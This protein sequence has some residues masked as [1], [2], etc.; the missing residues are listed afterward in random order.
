MMQLKRWMAV[1][2]VAML[3]SCGGG[4]G[5]SGSSV[6]PNPSGTAKAA[7]LTLVL[8]A[9]SVSNSGS[10]TVTA[11]VTAVDANRNTVAGI[12][13]TLS[14]NN[15]AT[16]LVS[17]TQTDDKGVVTGAVGIGG[18]KINRALVV[19][20]TSGTLTR[21]VVLQVVGAKL[22]ATLLPA[23]LAPSAAGKVQ[24][25]LL[26]I[27]SNPMVGVEIVVI[28]PSGQ[29][30]TAAT[31]SNG[32]YEFSYVAPAVAGAV[33]IRAAAGGVETIHSVIV[34]AGQGVIPVVVTPVQSASVSANP[35]VVSV[36]TNSTVNR[37]EIRAL[38]LAANNAPIKNIRVRLDLDGDPNFIGGSFT[39]GTSLLYS[40]AGGVAVGAYVPGTR[41]SPTDGVTVRACWDYADF[42]EGT[43]PNA[44]RTN[45]T[46]VAEPL[47]VSIGTNALI[48]FD[49]ANL[50]YIKKYVIQVVD[51]SGQAKQDVQVSP[52]LDLLRFR[53]GE[54]FISGD[55]WVK[56]HFDPPGSAI[57]VLGD[58]AICDNEDVNRN[59]V[60]EVFSNGVVED[61]NQSFNL[62][63][64]RPALEP[65]KA[66]V[67]WSYVGSSKTDATGIVIIQ[68]Q[69]PQNLGSWVDFNLTV[70]ASGVSGTEG[71]ANFDG[72]LPVPGPVLVDLK[73]DP[74]FIV[75]PYGV[76]TSP[77][78][79]VS[80]PGSSKQFLLCTNPN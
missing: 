32:D 55:R 58:A 56:F 29:Q 10:D 43:C 53:K 80:P 5:D 27:N 51:S 20:A 12:P 25:R 70:S 4:G 77:V 57:T 71:R 63:N 1:L 79:A 34:Q 18:T 69:Y 74:A 42:A 26:D 30:V 23:V 9:Q 14:V 66:D 73:N 48:S 17:G 75:S 38:F 13:V 49:A 44:V 76:Q 3:S 62:V 45:L 24:Y 11:T 65:R 2:A 36:N 37:S 64:G 19:T 68:L 21:E 28:G 15:G 54:Y 72:V 35:S 52:S 47:S 31:G 40:D 41:N 6:F 60:A 7:D 50:L 67:S 22:T 39:S 8:S 78:I 33:D 61:A 16:V 59:G 46:V